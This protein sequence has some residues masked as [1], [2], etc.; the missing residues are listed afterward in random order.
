ME[1]TSSRAVER[2]KIWKSPIG[3]PRWARPSLL[4]IAAVA[5]FLYSWRAGT[6]LEAYYAAAVRSMSMSWHDFAFAAFD[7]AG[8]V[9]LDKLPGAFWVQALSVRLFGL[10]TWSIV[11]P[12]VVEGVLS[13]LVI[14]RVVRRLCGAKAG[15]L[16]AA[17][18]AVSP[19]NVSL[20]RGNI[21]DTL[22][23]LL[24]LLAADATVAALDGGR[25]A[26]ILL[27]G[28]WVGLAFQAKMIEAW[29]VLPAFLLVYTVC[30]PGSW[31]RRALGV[32]AMAAATAVISVSWMTAVTLTPAS[33][34][35]YV[36]GSQNNSVFQQ[37]FVY[38]GI[39]RVDRET[40]NQLLS[41]SIGLNIPPPPPP[42]W[43]RL[44]VGHLGRD[45]GWLLPVAVI[46]C[47]AGLVT[48]R[49]R[50]RQDRDRAQ[51]IVWGTWLVVLAASFSVGASLNSYYVAALSPPI[52]ALVASGTRLA[53]Q[54]RRS[55]TTRI[56]V[57]A[58]VAL[59]AGYTLWL[60]PSSG[61]GLPDWLVWAVAAMAAGSIA[62]LAASI[63]GRRTGHLL[64]AALIASLVA[65]ALVPATASVSVAA[66]RLGPFDTPFQ[67]VSVTLSVRAF[68]GVLGTTKLLL[69]KIESARNGAP[70]L[71]ATQTSALAAPF[72]FDSGEEVL[73]I[74]GFTGTNP[75]P[76]LATIE[77][78]VHHGAFH[79]VIQS[80]SATDPR[81]TWIARHCIALAQP[82]GPGL[83]TTGRYALHY[84]IRSS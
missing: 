19:A 45:I 35:P 27:A 83:P 77:R 23:I 49:R 41:S 72:I 74:G 36:D 68:F 30:A 40:P 62:L 29:L 8:T 64:A 25:W 78:L 43:K 22:M 51:A 82:K 58:T 76:T 54:R 52:A 57:V 80:P 63:I 14:Y 3:Q 69:P 66:E 26:W 48:T 31:R 65:V 28:F 18:L 60:L 15:L 47:I 70:Y 11:M 4:V 7:P 13:I 56:V 84:C 37:V 55:A 6:Y 34:R 38:N 24:L 46:S 32:G 16:A 33:S 10:H 79:L 50:P 61:T 12:Q 39:G 71:M 9:T 21:S 42:S 81:L 17:L 1:S 67:P 73:P 2:L 44:L 75:S 20:D 59:T 5:G 53:W